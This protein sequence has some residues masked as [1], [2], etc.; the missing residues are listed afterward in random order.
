MSKKIITFRKAVLQK[1][2]ILLITFYFDFDTKEYVKSFGGVRWSNTLKGFYVPFS[3]K[4]TNSFFKYLRAKGYYVDYSSLKNKA[5]I[6]KPGILKQSEQKKYCPL[7]TYNQKRLQ[8]YKSY[9]NG[10]RLSKSTV[11]VYSNFVKLFLEHIGELRSLDIGQSHFRKYAEKIVQ[12]KEYSIS[13]HRQL[14]G[15]LNHFSILFCNEDF[16][17]SGLR[18]PKKNKSLP[19]VLSQ[20]EV[21]SLIRCTA[22]LKHRAIIAL[23]Y[24]AGLRIG[25]GINLRLSDIDLDRMQLR[26]HLGKGRKDRYVGVAKSFL[27]LLNNYLATYQP[28]V[29]FIEGKEGAQ[30]TASSIRK[31]LHR[32][33]KAAGIHKKITPHSLRHSYATHLIENGVGLRHVQEL[34]G[35][36]KP[37]TTMIYTHIAK[38]DLLQIKSPLD[39]AVEQLTKTP[40]G[41]S[42]ISIARNPNQ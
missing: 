5:I 37:E 27:P 36:S 19:A 40:K 29:Y 41:A 8:E 21:I 2:E 26:I 35:H 28:K 34:L 38:K 13:T 39:M 18:R 15:A 24:S 32:A 6:P 12:K 17:Q 1:Q 31:F 11:A 7:S 4:V 30:Y 25:E 33:C 22:N 23:L 3:K 42:N 16:K 20:K 14:I 9:L 10:L